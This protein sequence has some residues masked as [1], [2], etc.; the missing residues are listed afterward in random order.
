MYSSMYFAATKVINGTGQFE[1]SVINSAIHGHLYSTVSTCIS[2]ASAGV[3][4]T[5]SRIAQAPAAE[6][7]K[8]SG[9]RQP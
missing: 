3:T 9:V 1:E 4:W 7:E 8:T 6:H 2:L 5:S